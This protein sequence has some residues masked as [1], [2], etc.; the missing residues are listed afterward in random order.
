MCLWSA[1]VYFSLGLFSAV[2]IRDKLHVTCQNRMGKGSL[3]MN[4]NHE[5]FDSIPKDTG[6]IIGACISVYGD[7]HKS[8]VTK[9]AASHSRYISRQ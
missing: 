8:C 2:K 4:L 3:E 5:N 9:L 1:V 6:V 7:Q